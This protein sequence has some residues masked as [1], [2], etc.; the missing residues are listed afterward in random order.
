MHAALDLVLA[1]AAFIGHFSIAVY[2]FNR[3]HAL[4]WPWK[5]IKVLERLL[6]AAAA[7]TLIVYGAR[8]VVAGGFAIGWANGA[9]TL[10]GPWLWY[11]VSSWLF[12]ALALPLWLVPKLTARQ[13]NVLMSND[14][15]VLDVAARLGRKPVGTTKGR[16][17]ARFPGTEIFRLHVARKTLLVADL[18]RELDG[19]TIAHLSDLHMTGDL[20]QD[21][22]REVVAATNALEPDLVAVTGDILEKSRCLPWIPATLGQLQS[23]HSK[24]FVLGNHEMRLGD[25]APLRQALVAAGLVDLGGQTR[26]LMIN[27]ASILVAGSELPWFG[28]APDLPPTPHSALRTAHFRLLLSHTPD[29]LPWARRH[30]F[31]L[32]LAGHNHGGQIRL[33]W[34]GALITPSRYGFRYAGGLYHA[35]P[36]LLHVS[37]GICGV[38]PIR[39]NCP[40]EIALLVLKSG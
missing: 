16:V 37:R 29:Q 27:G 40:P 8:S 9:W 26:E 13:P 30:G 19:L 33:P 7:A 17:Y 1:L 38:P 2:L 32:M 25:P 4:A 23:R 24:F 39:L 6:L 18:P 20:D 10:G 5:L 3:L 35:P 36:T 15:Q 31:Q 34:I 22:F 11:A 14:T 21:F 12:A 28:A